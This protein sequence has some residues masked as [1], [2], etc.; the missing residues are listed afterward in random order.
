MA[1]KKEITKEY[2]DSLKIDKVNNE[3]AYNDAEHIYWNTKHKDRMYTSVT[4]LVSKYYEKFD[5]YFWSRYKALEKLI[6]L[7]EFTTS[8]IKSTLLSKK[9]WQ[10]SYYE[11]FDIDKELFENTVSEIIAGYNETRDKACE[12]G[13]IYHNKRENE[14]YDKSQH[15]ISEYNFGLDLPQIFS[16]EK[17]NFDLNRENAVLPEYLVYYSSPS[18]ILN[19]AGQIDILLK[20]GNDIYILDYKTNAKGIESKAYFNPRTKKKKMM[21]APL[22]HV[23]DTTLEHYTLQLSIYAYMLQQINPEFNVKLLRIIHVD[24]EMNE[25]LIDL[26]YRKE[27][28]RKLFKHY[29]KQIVIDFYRKHGRM[30]TSHEDYFADK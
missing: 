9:Q 16:C 5:E 12:R 18:G 11:L 8:G 20:Q 26:Q 6:G 4:T 2:I 23:E 28:V 22:G 1:K 15:L 24:G 3:L 25:T 7:E 29:E 30:L 10:D 19:M 21:Y 13:T 17:N 14:F 27:D